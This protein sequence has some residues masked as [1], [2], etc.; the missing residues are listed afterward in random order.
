[1]P[2]PNVL[3]LLKAGIVRVGEKCILSVSPHK[4]PSFPFKAVRLVTITTNLL[5]II[6]SSYD[7]KGLHPSFSTG[8]KDF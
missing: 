8:T 4:M 7:G 5:K 1:V 6:P 3:L 2:S